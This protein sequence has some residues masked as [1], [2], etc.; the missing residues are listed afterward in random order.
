MLASVLALSG[1]ITVH[2]HKTESGPKPT[3]IRESPGRSDLVT[4]D[5]DL[6]KAPAPGDSAAAGGTDSAGGTGASG[7]TRPPARDKLCTMVRQ[8]AGKD[9]GRQCEHWFK[10]TDPDL[11]KLPSEVCTMVRNYADATAEATCKRWLGA[12]D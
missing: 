4:P 10:T 7:A 11:V 12:K 6:S 9:A 1:C 3:P 2:P 8:Y 5:P